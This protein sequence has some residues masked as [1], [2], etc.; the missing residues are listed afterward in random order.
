MEACHDIHVQGQESQIVSFSGLTIVEQM[1]TDKDESV[2]QGEGMA[3]NKRSC[4]LQLHHD[5]MN[6]WSILSPQ[7]Y[8]ICIWTMIV[9]LL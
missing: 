7:F 9:L 2:T 5:L 1:S 6:N 3:P 8:R 4:N